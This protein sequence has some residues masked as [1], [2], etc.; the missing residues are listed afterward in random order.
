MA[1][2]HF[3][4]TTNQPKIGKQLKLG[5]IVDIPYN[6]VMLLKMFAASLSFIY[7]GHLITAASR[8]SMYYGHIMFA[9]SRLSL[10]HGYLSAAS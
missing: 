2:Q 10:Y 6:T 7:Y 9:A 3:L 1:G 5:Y 8:L 4:T